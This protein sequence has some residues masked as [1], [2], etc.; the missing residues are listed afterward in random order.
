M[1]EIE[2]RRSWRRSSDRCRR[3]RTRSGETR[4]RRERESITTTRHNIRGI[5]KKRR[6]TGKAILMIAIKMTTTIDTRNIYI[7]K[8][9][10]SD[11]RSN[12]MII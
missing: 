11:R 9:I 2:R 10:K 5:L 3:K 1:T 8:S 4:R 12:S 6:K 7:P